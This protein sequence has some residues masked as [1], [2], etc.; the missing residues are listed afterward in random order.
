MAMVVWSHTGVLGDTAPF[1]KQKPVPT[2]TIKFLIW[3]VLQ[4]QHFKRLTEKVVFHRVR[5]KYLSA[6]WCYWNW[7]IFKNDQLARQSLEPSLVKIKEIMLRRL[8]LAQGLFLA[9]SYTS[10]RWNPKIFHRS[11]VTAKFRLFWVPPRSVYYW[12]CPWV[13]IIP[14]MFPLPNFFKKRGEKMRQNLGK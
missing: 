3:F 6:R 9:P 14:E 1:L 13:I 4:K 2:Y 8:N 12:L 5:E 7:P 11:Q 10:L